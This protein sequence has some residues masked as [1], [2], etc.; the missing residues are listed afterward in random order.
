MN[1]LFASRLTELRLKS[2]FSQKQLA[3]TLHVSASTFSN[4][5]NG[6]YLPPLN[7]VC[8]LAHELDCSLDYLC[9]LSKVN[10]PSRHWERPLNEHMNLYRLVKLLISLK[11]KELL[12][13]LRYAEYL[14]YK[15]EDGTYLQEPPISLVAE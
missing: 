1:H 7:K 11:D 3:I 13:L 5:E 8:N 12:E 15:R 14:K 10:I 4:Y 6:I 9:G 2:G